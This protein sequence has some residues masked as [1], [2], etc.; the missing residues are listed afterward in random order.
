MLARITQPCSSYLPN[1]PLSQVRHVLLSEIKGLLP[2]TKRLQDLTSE[3]AAV[4]AVFLLWRS[5]VYR[6]SL[7]IVKETVV[8]TNS[9]RKYDPS[10]RWNQMVSSFYSYVPRRGKSAMSAERL[11]DR[12]TQ[13][14]T[15]LLD[16]HL[17]Y[18][19]PCCRKILCV[20]GGNWSQRKSSVN[21]YD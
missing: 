10:T 9:R 1:H 6:H 11:V 14:M 2:S 5:L 13:K 19:C 15:N 8:Q 7:G 3:N 16:K 17:I 18:P 20:C 4:V 21:C 12:S